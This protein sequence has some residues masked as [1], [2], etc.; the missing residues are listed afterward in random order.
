MAIFTD[1]TDQMKAAMRAKD[2][3]R[4]R[5]LRNIRAA[6]IETMK[7]DGSSELSDEAC[8]TVLRRLAKQRRDSIESYQAGGRGDLVA[9]EEAELVVVESFLPAGPDEATIRGWVE[10]AIEATGATE[11]RHMGKVMGVVMKD[12]RGEVDGN[13]VKKTALELLRG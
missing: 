12:H 11:P 4:L 6:F 3:D 8:I 13:A 10:A 7:K 5:G 9:A 2:A 1:I